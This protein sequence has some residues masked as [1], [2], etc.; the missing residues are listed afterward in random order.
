MAKL[1]NYKGSVQL[2]AGII[3]KNNG[4]FPLLEANAIQVDESG[5]RLDAELQE[6]KENKLETGNDVSAKVVNNKLVLKVVK[7]ENGNQ[8][9]PDVTEEDNGK[10]LCVVNGKWKAVALSAA[11]S[12]VKTYIDDYINEALGGDY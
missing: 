6:I 9:S 7:S 4:D 10:I 2:I 12:P 3:Q 1:N 5:K 11:D 8:E